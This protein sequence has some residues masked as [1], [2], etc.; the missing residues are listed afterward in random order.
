MYSCDDCVRYIPETHPPP[1]AFSGSIG[2]DIY[3]MH[4]NPPLIITAGRAVPD[5]YLKSINNYYCI[6]TLHATCI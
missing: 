1:H 2:I 5:V 3:I 4:S 6:Y